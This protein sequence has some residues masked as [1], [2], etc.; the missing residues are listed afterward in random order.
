MRTASNVL[1]RLLLF[2]AGGLIIL[3]AVLEIIASVNALNDPNIG[4]WNWANPNGVAAMIL[5]FLA[6]L[7]AIIGLTAIFACIRGRR[8]FWLFL[9]AIFLMITPVYS[10][11]TLIQNGLWTGSW[12]QIGKLILEFITPIMYFLGTIFLVAP[13]RDAR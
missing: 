5:F 2:A 9:F 7:D 6:I 3:G 1:A 12:E 4:W 8:S 11:I 10:V 13:A